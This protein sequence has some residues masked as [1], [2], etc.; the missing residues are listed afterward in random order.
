MNRRIIV[1]NDDGIDAPGL[2]ALVEAVADLGEVVVV[3]PMSEWSGCG[4]KVTTHAPI[5]VERRGELRYAVDGTPGDCVR[6]ALH[7]IAPDAAWVF[8]GINAGGNL[9]ADIVHSGTVAAAREAT[10]HGRAAIALSHYIRRDRRIDWA[11]AARFAR[12]VLAELIQEFPGP[13][14]LWNVNLPHVDEGAI[15]GVVR[16]EP[17]PSPLPIAYRRDGDAF[18]YQGDYHS[19]ER[20]PG[21]DI[22]V[23]FGGA[24]A[25]SRARVL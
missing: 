8:A 5:R 1:T 23:C 16:C 25:V 3:A 14:W 10:L 4:H 9:G 15:P 11:Q 7:G 13:G 20:L 2:A 17:D 6:L 21:R 12:P 19:R 22:D 18:A 24:I